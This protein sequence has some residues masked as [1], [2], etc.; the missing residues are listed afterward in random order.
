[1]NVKYHSYIIVPLKF[2]EKVTPD[3][4]PL[5]VDSMDF[6]E[7]VKELFKAGAPS[8]MCSAYQC[9]PIV[10]GDIHIHREELRFN[11][12]DSYLFVFRTKVAF[13]ALGVAYDAIETLQQIRNPGYNETAAVYFNDAGQGFDFEGES[14]TV[15][16]HV[17][18][19]RQKLG[20]WGKHIIT[21]RNVGYVIR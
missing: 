21:V 15:D 8:Q 7:N 19:L 4:E 3:L 18:T 16:M 20:E 11:V 5:V 17:S 1:M 12:T 9:P 6:T 2:N 14:R 10:E 13:L